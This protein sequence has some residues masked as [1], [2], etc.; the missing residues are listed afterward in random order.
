MKYLKMTGL[1]LTFAL[2]C[3]IASAQ[4]DRLNEPNLNKPRLFDAFPNDIT[5][6]TNQLVNLLS[7]Q[8]GETV[9]ITLAPGFQ[10]QGQV[11]STAN[12]YDN[13]LQ[14]VVISSSNFNGA[15]LTFT[16][17]ADENKKVSYTGRSIS[18]QH[19]DL[20]ELVNRDNQYY[21]IKKKFYDLVNE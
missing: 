21:F 4:A 19:G 7:Y 11:V 18:F 10:F 14:S 6:N 16:Q 3:I 8:V 20:F 13:T 2:F 5:V 12:L 1:G 15:R 9:N 17:V